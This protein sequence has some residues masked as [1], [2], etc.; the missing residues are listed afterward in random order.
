MTLH[1]NQQV[2]GEVD[3]GAPLP[4][5]LVERCRQH[6]AFSEIPSLFLAAAEKFFLH[7]VALPK[8]GIV[9]HVLAAGEVEVL[10]IG[11]KRA[12]ILVRLGG[13]VRHRLRVER[14]WMVEDIVIETGFPK[15]QLR[16]LDLVGVL[17]IGKQVGVVH[18][19]ARE[20]HRL[21]ILL[22]EV[23]DAGG[24]EV[25]VGSEIGAHLEDAVEGRQGLRHIGLVTP[26]GNKLVTL[27]RQI[28]PQSIV[29]IHVEI[30]RMVGKDLLI[31]FV[32]LLLL[33]RL[34]KI[35]RFLENLLAILVHSL[36]AR[37]IILRVARAGDDHEEQEE[38][39]REAVH[40]TVF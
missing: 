20:L 39:E 33:P 4:V 26:L 38:Y 27:Q 40:C 23:G 18:N 9:R 36:L 1:K 22:V 24:V 29:V 34:V 31:E 25:A 37:I 17:R 5:R 3:G 13:D 32:C 12:K 16:L 35:P 10:A 14:H 15:D 2:I 11:R 8:R 30:F 6:I 21:R 7:A 19:D 28:I